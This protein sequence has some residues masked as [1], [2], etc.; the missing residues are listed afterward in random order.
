MCVYTPI[1]WGSIKEAQNHSSGSQATQ[2]LSWYSSKVL[3]WTTFYTNNKTP[4]RILQFTSPFELLYYY[5]PFLAHLRVFGSLA[6][7]SNT[8]FSD[9]FSPKAIPS[10]FMGYSSTQ[11]GY[12]IYDMHSNPSLQVE[13]SVHRVS[14]SFSI[15]QVPWHSPISHI[16]FIC[17][18]FFYSYY[19]LS[20][21]F[22]IY[23][24]YP[25]EL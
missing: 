7:A 4:S 1:E 17:L 20:S 15:W 11:K 23:Y 21:T 19:T 6:Y 9:K 14:F 24:S 5:P 16:W 25:G 8:N 2:V 3:G 12:I 18:K 10:I 13:C 22:F